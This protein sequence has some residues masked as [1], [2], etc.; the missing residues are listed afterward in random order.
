MTGEDLRAAVAAGVLGSEKGY[1]DLLGSENYFLE[2]QNHGLPDE[3]RLRNAKA[4]LSRATG[5]PLVATQDFHYLDREDA[6]AHDVLL[7]I[8]TGKSL[9]DPN[10]LR[11]DVDRFHFT[12]ADEMKATFAGFEDAV[13]NTRVVADRVS[14]EL[15]FSTRLPRFVSG[16]CCAQSGQSA[17]A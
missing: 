2:I 15:D 12:S 7:A 1:R 14:L 16:M 5:I 10:R 11:F 13:R 4:E 9:D 8:G 17:G 6:E 3:E